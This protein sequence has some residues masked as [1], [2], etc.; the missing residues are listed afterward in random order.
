MRELS[1]N[2]QSSGV[3]PGGATRSGPRKHKLDRTHRIVAAILWCTIVVLLAIALPMTKKPIE[4]TFV[5]IGS[6][7]MLDP[8]LEEEKALDA[9]ITFAT[10]EKDEL[11]AAQKGGIGSFTED[12]VFTAFDTAMAKGKE[13]ETHALSPF[14]N[15]SVA[16]NPAATSWIA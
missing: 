6:T 2:H 3:D 8:I 1:W 16:R 11:C 9:R 7:V 14:G 13:I 4:C 10:T 15:I 12:E 5:K